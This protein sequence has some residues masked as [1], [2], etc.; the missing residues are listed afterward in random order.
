MSTTDGSRADGLFE[1]QAE[2]VGTPATSAGAPGVRFSESSFEREPGLRLYHCEFVPDRL[3]RGAALVVLMH[4]YGEHC[5][6][7]DDFARYLARRGHVVCSMDARGHGRSQGQRGYVRAYADSVDDFADFVR[8]A[9]VRHASA[10]TSKGLPLV[11]LGH[12]NGGLI[13][14]RAVQAGVL[15]PRG[16]V[17]TSPLLGLR[18]QRR[19]VPDAVARVLSAVV[20][21]LPAPNGIRSEDLTHDPVLLE[22]H[23]RD[24][25]VHGVATSR[26]Y[27]S[28]TL[29]TRA[30]L[31]AAPSVRLPLLIAQAELDPIVDPAAVAAF[32]AR[33]GSAD[34]RLIVRPGA[35]HE[36]LN[37]TARHELFAIASEWIERVA[38]G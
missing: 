12:S 28:M 8:R 21:R 2:A 18:H 20:P 14:V 22:A 4:G 38:A 7:Y 25:W 10:S 33:A 16:L 27:W 35:H 5:R 37:E 9:Q 19:A 23:R 32:Y 24:R 30:A 3:E 17:L 1:A 36:V 34:K 11:V 29:A 26:W 15:E 6:R 13:A 31:A